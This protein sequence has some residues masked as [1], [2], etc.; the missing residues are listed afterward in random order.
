MFQNSPLTA[1]LHLSPSDEVEGG[2]LAAAAAKPAPAVASAPAAHQRL[3]PPAPLSSDSS[4][5]D[6]DE[7]SSFESDGEFV[8]AI[9]DRA[10]TGDSQVGLQV[11][12]TGQQPTTASNDSHGSSS[13]N[14]PDHTMEV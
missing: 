10:L 4:S 1:Q 6:S 11:Q 8:D 9:V 14:Q 2:S 3:V 5:S 12:S 13:S 7:L